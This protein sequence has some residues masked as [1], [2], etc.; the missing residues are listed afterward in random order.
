MEN[1]HLKCFDCGRH[2]PNMSKFAQ[3]AHLHNLNPY[4][5]RWGH[6]VSKKQ[7]ILFGLAHQASKMISQINCKWIDSLNIHLICITYLAWLP[8]ALPACP[9]KAF[10]ASW[11]F[12]CNWLNTLISMSL[13][14]SIW[15]SWLNV[16]PGAAVRMW[17]NWSDGVDV[18][19]ILSSHCAEQLLSV[20]NDNKRLILYS[21]WQCAWV[22]LSVVC[23]FPVTITP[24]YFVH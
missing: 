8:S 15:P 21:Q 22:W 17:R 12:A 19:R 16:H 3:T 2:C 13:R 18:D 20:R 10:K 9:Y 7:L 11:S 1:F 5:V 4:W 6:Q 23:I 14:L 24:S